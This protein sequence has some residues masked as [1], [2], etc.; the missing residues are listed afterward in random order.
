MRV[1]RLLER[2]LSRIPFLREL[3]AILL[4]SAELNP[5]R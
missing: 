2:I 4:L 5:K 3:D 1:V